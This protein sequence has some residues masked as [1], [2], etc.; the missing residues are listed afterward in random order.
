MSNKFENTL[1]GLLASFVIITIS[2]FILITVKINEQMALEIAGKCRAVLVEKTNP[3]FLSSGY[4]SSCTQD[5][6]F[7][8]EKL[9]KKST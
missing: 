2:I 1:I 6:R 4:E 5:N 7:I 3:K 8:L 9:P